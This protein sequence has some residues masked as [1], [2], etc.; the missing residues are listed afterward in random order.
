MKMGWRMKGAAL[1]VAGLWLLAQAA[2]AQVSGEITKSNGQ[3]IQGTLSWKA[4]VKQYEVR[5]PNAA[6]SFPVPLDQVAGVRVAPPAALDAAAKAVRSGQ[7]TGPHIATLE[8]I[9]ND[10]LMLEH[11][12]TAMRWLAEA[13]LKQGSG[14]DVAKLF[15]K[16]MEN[17]DPATVAPDAM[18]A[19]WDVLLEGERYSELRQQLKW[20]IEQG[21]RP[22]AASAQLLRGEMDMRRGQFKDALVDGFLRTV[23][24]FQDVRDVQPE[25]LF[26]AAKCFE[27]L[28]ESQNA[29]KMRKKLLSEFP[30]SSYSRQ[31]GS[32]A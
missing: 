12:V 32:G 28:G 23:V 21:P 10:Y 30:D 29:E 27:E 13:K 2:V 8:K 14:K 22:V 17:R 15:D 3:K 19:Y 20:G 5:P 25:A 7:Y 31:L 1:A 11:D 18:R 26:K 9:V 4:A 16:V 6:A 24:L